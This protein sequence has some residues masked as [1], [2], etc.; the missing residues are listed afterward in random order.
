M[1]GRKHSK[2]PDSDLAV[3]ILT[4]E[5]LIEGYSDPKDDLFE[6]L[7]T[8]N[9]DDDFNFILTSVRVQPA[10]ILCIPPFSCQE[11]HGS[12]LS[13]IIALMPRD[14][15]SL[16]AARAAFEDYEYPFRAEIFA[17]QYLVRG[18]LMSDSEDSPNYLN[19][20]TVKD[21]EIESL[22]PEAKMG[23]LSFPLLFLNGMHIHGFYLV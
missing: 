23:H 15:A 2:Q 12:F 9:P 8:A 5:Y 7:S 10:G 3:Q 21:A 22:L 14:D 11:W 18:A 13:S 4:P 19:F 17:G 16:Q 20:V 6:Y 1:F